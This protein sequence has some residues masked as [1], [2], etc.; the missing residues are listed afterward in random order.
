M[1]RHIVRGENYLSVI[2]PQKMKEIQRIEVANGPGMTMFGQ[3]GK[4]AFVC[5]SF[6]PEL[7]VIDRADEVRQCVGK[8]IQV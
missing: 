6:T 3:D 4:C 7:A 2:D 8:S 1:R 5:S